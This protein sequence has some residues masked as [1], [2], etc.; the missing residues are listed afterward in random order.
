MDPRD[1]EAHLDESRVLAAIRAAEAKGRGEVRVHVAQDEVGDAHEAAVLTFES[2]G[3]AGTAE[4]NGI[5]IYVAP[6]GR[7]FAVIGDQGVHEKCGAGF[8][9]AVAEAMQAE[10]RAGRFTEGLVR[11]VESAGEVLARFFPREA[12]RA[13]VNELPDAISRD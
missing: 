13:D 8:W 4:R 9:R 3:M 11:G 2:L 7:T 12:G 5:L 10:F 1:F 6:R